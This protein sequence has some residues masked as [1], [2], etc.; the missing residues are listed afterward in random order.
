LYDLIQ[1]IPKFVKA[2]IESKDKSGVIKGNFHLGVSMIFYLGT[3]YR[4]A[5][6]FHVNNKL[7]Q[8]L[9]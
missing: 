2:V 7:R 5:G 9:G 8:V 1:E 6:F 4:I 3:I